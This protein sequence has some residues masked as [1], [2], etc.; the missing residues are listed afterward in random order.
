LGGGQG[1]ALPSRKGARKRIQKKTKKDEMPVK[2][3]K[4]QPGGENSSG[5]KFLSTTRRGK[6]E[7]P[8]KK[9]A[10]E[11]WGVGPKEE[12]TEQ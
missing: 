7:G 8:G 4:E 12:R 3:E 10:N 2:E 11:K 9:K 1:G 6:E 5:G